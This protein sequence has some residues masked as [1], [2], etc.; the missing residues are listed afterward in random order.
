MCGSK[1]CGRAAIAW[2]LWAAR[3]VHKLL[4]DSLRNLRPLFF[5]VA[6]ACVYVVVMGGIV[7]YF[8]QPVSNAQ[9]FATPVGGHETIILA[10]GSQIELNTD[11]VVRV[12]E[13]RGERDVALE[14]GEALFRI[15]H[16]PNR[17]FVVT[18]GMRR[19]VDWERN[20]SFAI[21]PTISKSR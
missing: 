12:S 19:I 3:R 18:A 16:D 14:K 9:T 15:K 4:M 21:V 10:D 7:Y 1:M 5:R 13:T 6:A 8:L 20:S 11:T 17:L 2:P